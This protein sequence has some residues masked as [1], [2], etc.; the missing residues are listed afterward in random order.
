MSITK[1]L[2]QKLL[3]GLE[4]RAAIRVYNHMKHV[5]PAALGAAGISI[6]LLAQGPAAYPWRAD[7]NEEA[8][9][10]VEISSAVNVG[11]SEIRTAIA[12]LQ[13]FSDSELHDLGI[14]RGDIENVVRF[15]RPGID[16]QAA[17]DD[18]R[19]AA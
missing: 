19:A 3:S 16:D 15:G 10:R 7:Q 2:K 12:E 9:A 5:D 11:K 17:N 6:D 4:R 13:S 18:Q 8:S 14:S 1:S